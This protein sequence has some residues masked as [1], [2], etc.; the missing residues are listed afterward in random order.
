MV[1]GSD[2]VAVGLVASLAHPGGNVTGVTA[3]TLG[4]SA[5]RVELLKETVPGVSR[6][7]V[8]RH[9]SSP[10]ATSA[11]RETQAAAKKLGLR[12]YSLEVSTPADF[13]AAFTTATQEQIDGFICLTDA[14]TWSQR[15]KIVNFTAKERLPAI[16]EFREFAELG[17]LMSYG[18]SF[19]ALWQRAAYFVD[20]ILKGAKPADLPV[21]QASKFELIL[22]LRTATALGLTIPQ[23]MLLRADEVIR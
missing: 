23:S 6:L 22:N 12:V 21:E 7:G 13:D 20:R 9:R 19:P 1:L 17:G 15:T 2:P 3:L 14:I 11:F 4:L 5:K 10:I 8:L 16:Y 18:A